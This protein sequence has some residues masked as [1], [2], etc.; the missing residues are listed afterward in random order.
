MV[1]LG[2][3]SEKQFKLA[4]LAVGLLMVVNLSFPPWINRY[5][6]A[7]DDEDIGYASIL[8]VSNHHYPHGDGKGLTSGWGLSYSNQINFPKLVLQSVIILIIGCGVY[9][10]LRPPRRGWRSIEPEDD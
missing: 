4:L 6:F 5:D 3:L 10:G 9:F 2:M 1:G 7:R 8:T